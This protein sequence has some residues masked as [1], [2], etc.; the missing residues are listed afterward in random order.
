MTYACPTWVY[1]VDAHLLNLQRLQ[2]RVLCTTG[3]PDRCTP[4]RKLHVAHKIPYLYDYINK[5]C[6][7]QTELLLNHVNQNVR[8]IEHA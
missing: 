5:L 3:N 2:N 8:G 4:V 7:T 1:A 6:R